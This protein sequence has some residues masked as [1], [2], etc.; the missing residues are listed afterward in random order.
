MNRTL[1]RRAPA[2][3]AVAGRKVIPAP[4]PRMFGVGAV[5]MAAGLSLVLAAFRGDGIWL[6][7]SALPLYGLGL[8]AIGALVWW[9]STRPRTG[10]LPAW[11]SP[12]ALI[13]GW[14]LA[15]IYLPSLAVFV[16]DDL[17]DDF[18]LGLGGE[19]VLVTGLPLTCAALAMLSLAYHAT[20]FALR[21]GAPPDARME[22]P[23]ALRRILALYLI[24]AAARAL[25]L[26]TLGTAFG[27]DLTAWGPLQSLDQWIGYV[28]D[29][30]YLAL[31]LLV[32]DVIRRRTPRRW[33]GLPL[34]LELTFGATSGYLTPFIWPVLLCIA[35]VAALDRLRTRH[36]AVVA[37][38]A[39]AASTFVPVVA[40]IREDRRGTIGTRVSGGIADAIA[41]PTRYWFGG[42]TSG[43]GAYDK[44]FGRQAEVASATGL[45]LMMTPAVVPF[46]GL[47]RFLDIPLNLV[48]RVIWPDKPISSRGV[49]FSVNFRGLDEKTTSS[50]AMTIFSEGY[51]FFGWTGVML[52]MF[53]AGAALAVMR[54]ALDSP[55]FALVHLALVPT[56]LNIEPDLSSYLI[57]LVQRSI[58]FA[59]VFVLLAHTRTWRTREARIRR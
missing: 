56:I 51:L 42:V 43:D 21:S 33:L 54:R 26:A 2:L 15:W 50:S 16:D 58:V 13:A 28:E 31:A 14:T 17:L 47:A 22:Q 25:R 44:F 4:L 53:L 45:V 48:P 23:V 34:L 3:A 30:R 35:T 27:A 41:T 12:P 24:S 55:R 19:A 39:L 10:P 9:E 46:E 40:A 29:L 6:V 49:W 52:G 38:A 18:T 32:A 11:T 5:S 20:T 7:D 57:V 59:V 37:A 8:L 36:V 1:D